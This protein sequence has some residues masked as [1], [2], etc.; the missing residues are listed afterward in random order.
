MRRAI[1]LSLP[2]GGGPARGA[3]PLEREVVEVGGVAGG[4]LDRRKDR[5]RRGGI[6]LHLRTAP[7]AVHVAVREHH[8]KVVGLAAVD[9]V[10]MA[11]EPELF[12]EIE[13]AVDRGRGC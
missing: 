7:L 8:L 10:V 9:A 5:L 2:R 4:P 1:A 11:G 6:K 3:V 12:E 13:R